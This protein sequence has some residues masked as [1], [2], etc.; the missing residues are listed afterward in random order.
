MKEFTKREGEDMKVKVDIR[1]SPKMKQIGEYYGMINIGLFIFQ[2]NLLLVVFMFKKSIWITHLVAFLILSCFS[3]LFKDFAPEKQKKLGF[4]IF[5]I[6]LLI[7]ALA[8]FDHVIVTGLSHVKDV[9]LFRKMS[10]II[11]FLDFAIL[12]SSIA[13]YKNE[14]VVKGFEG[15]YED[16]ILDKILGE[17][18]EEIKDGDAILGISIE[19]KKPVRL[20][21]KDR[22]LHMLI[23]GPTGSGKTSQSIIPMINRDMQWKEAGIIVLEPKGDLAEKVYAMARHYDRQV[24]YF[25]PILPDCPYFN[26]LF[27][28]ESDVV[29]NLATTFKMFS[30]G[31]SSFFLD[32]N[33]GLIRRA[34]KIVK[35]VKSDDA[36]FIDVSNLINGFK[37]GQDILNKFSRLGGD[38]EFVAENMEIYQWF[39]NDYLSGLGGGK[40][41]TKTYEH[42]SAFRTQVAKLISNKY[43]RKVLNPPQG[44][45]DINF[46]KSLADGEVITIGTA[47][48]ALRD[49]GR[50][51][52]YFIILQLQASVFRRPGNENT[53]RP[54]F[55]Y[56]D[57]FQVYSN[58]GFADMLTQGRSYK[59]AS[60][61]AT[62]ARDQIAMGSGADGKSFL[63]LVSTNARNL[64]IYPG[65]N[66]DDASYYSAE[67]GE[68][69]EKT[70]QKGISRQK[71]NP[72]YGIGLKAPTE[73]IRYGEELKAR[74]TATDI[75]YREF[76]EISYCLIKNNSIQ[77][78]GVSK[79]E[80]I[81]KELNEKLDEMV[82]EYNELQAQ[83]GGTGIKRDLEIS[84]NK[85]DFNA[86][87]DL[88]MDSVVIKTPEPILDGQD[89][90]IP[91][92]M[93][94]LE[95]IQI[96]EDQSIAPAK[97]VVYE[98]D[99]DQFIEDGDI[100]AKEKNGPVLTYDDYRVAG[101][102]INIGE[103]EDDLI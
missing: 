86:K 24:L 2:V 87:A 19:N 100:R 6:S 77:S 42:C 89:F 68:V 54:C 90:I 83:K 60:H 85:E 65:G 73:S 81:P 1:K 59:V 11:Y 15:I 99:R 94:E 61:L 45:N 102:D 10:N 97:D 67:F 58:P 101:N 37:E 27:G 5:K 62:Q 55:L 95:D 7:F 34:I 84:K 43:L 75:K 64:I 31:S 36:T 72:L 13:F 32:Q 18:D 52:G 29:E 33:D 78:P 82:S 50:F 47:Q 103:E 79:I 22:F 26:P 17:P 16:S 91:D 20:P 70:V 93:S 71:F 66:A 51:L 3:L 56:I 40:G 44:R 39:K 35:R 57:E 76:G 88:D 23:L 48:G 46:D 8:V 12:I 80:Y 21:L 14:V 53:R 49:L 9:V 92:P 63:S 28:D 41:G 69:I 4:N 98:E 30:V 96:E 74:F 25:N 38:S